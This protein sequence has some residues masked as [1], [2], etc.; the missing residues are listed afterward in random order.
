MGLKKRTTWVIISIVILIVLIIVA[1]IYINFLSSAIEPNNDGVIFVEIPRGSITSD[2][3]YIL[4]EKDLIKSELYFE[5]RIKNLGHDSELKAGTYELSK[6]MDVDLIIKKLV[7]GNN[8]VESV[9]FTI[10]EGYTIEQIADKLSEQGLVDKQRFVQLSK[11]GNFDFEF[12]NE[13]PDNNEIKYK[14]EGYLFPETYEIKLGATEEEYIEK[15]LSQFEKEWKSEWDNVIAKNGLT[16]HQIV[17]LS[18]IIE[19][20]VRVDDERPIVSGVFYNRLEDY[21]NL[22]S[23]ATVQYVLGK[24]KESLTYDDLEIK[25]PYNTYN[26]YGLP[27]GPIGNPGRL[28]LGAAVYPEDNEYYFFV[29]KKDDS[30]SHYF[31]RTYEEHLNYDAM[32]RGNW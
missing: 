2:I 30:G 10:P 21:W 26:N 18:S 17:T 4:K 22:E 28:S 6:N 11:E 12:I 14:L 25:D 32:S 8:K 23:C 9:R 7:D 3:A 1:L 31:S 13:I 19:R 5:M 29:T 20:E 16:M 24:Q 27:P 15:M